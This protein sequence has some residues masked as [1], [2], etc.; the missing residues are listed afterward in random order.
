MYIGSRIW[1]PEEQKFVRMKIS[2]KA[3]RTVE[4]KGIQAVAK[5]Y[6][7]NLYQYLIAPRDMKKAPTEEST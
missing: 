6:G 5:D 7:I 2:T 3:L 1:W 4:K